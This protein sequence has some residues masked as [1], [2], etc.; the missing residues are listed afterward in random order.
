[1]KLFSL[2]VKFHLTWLTHRNDFRKYQAALSVKL[3]SLQGSLFLP[4]GVLIDWTVTNEPRLIARSN[5]RQ[6][7]PGKA[8]I[9]DP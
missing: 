1:M 5:I 2:I 6:Q 3:M 9:A 4:S 8:H 7:K